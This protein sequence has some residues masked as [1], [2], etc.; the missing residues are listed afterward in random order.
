MNKA[1]LMGRLTADPDIRYTAAEKPVAHFSIAVNRPQKNGG[2]TVDFFQ[3][4][5]WEGL[6]KICGEFLKK[7]K[8]VAVEGRIQPSKYKDKEGKERSITE[9]IASNVQMLDKK[10]KVAK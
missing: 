9:I 3:C 10:E 4:V 1:I 7:G 2:K 6:A 8:L 5:A